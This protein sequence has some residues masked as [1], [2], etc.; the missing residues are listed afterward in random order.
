[1]SYV[2]YL[3]EI[4]VVVFQAAGSGLIYWLLRRHIDDRMSGAHEHLNDEVDSLNQNLAEHVATA[5]D[6]LAGMDRRVCGV[7]KR[8]VTKFEIRDK[9]VICPSCKVKNAS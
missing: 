9:G 6:K 5:R 2:P 8:L 3:G 7:C 1:M 4:C